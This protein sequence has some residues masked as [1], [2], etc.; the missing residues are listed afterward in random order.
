MSSFFMRFFLKVSQKIRVFFIHRAAMRQHKG[1][2]CS[3][4]SHYIPPISSMITTHRPML[5]IN[6]HPHILRN[7]LLKQQAHAN[8]IRQY[9]HFLRNED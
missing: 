3:F 5:F 1:F 2:A 6:E 8:R 7:E 4:R 9:E